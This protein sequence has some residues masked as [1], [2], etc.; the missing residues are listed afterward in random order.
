[1]YRKSASQK[2]SN[3]N[4]KRKKNTRIRFQHEWK[5]QHSQSKNRYATAVYQPDLH[6]VHILFVLE[7]IVSKGQG[8]T[9]SLARPHPNRY[10][11]SQRSTVEYKSKNQNDFKQ[12]ANEC[13]MRA[14]YLI[15]KCPHFFPYEIHFFPS[16][17]SSSFSRVK[18][19][20]YRFQIGI[21]FAV[22]H[23][24]LFI[25]MFFFVGLCSSSAITKRH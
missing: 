19:E 2:K 16:S 10:R 11:N 21:R 1:M 8:D 20:F 25:P 5:S 7:N 18:S 9:R 12:K 13:A 4:Q 15:E 6:F 24:S 14:R 22:C 23:F 3:I 17:S